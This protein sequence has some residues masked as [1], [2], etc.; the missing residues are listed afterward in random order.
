MNIQD[1]ALLLVCITAIFS[2]ISL[3]LQIYVNRQLKKAGLRTRVPVGRMS[4]FVP[5]VLGW[6]HVEELEIME[7]M[8]F[9][10]IILVITVIGVIFSVMTLAAA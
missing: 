7:V 3:V 10:S 1:L 8:I 6:R 4:F 2:L 9:W 5:L